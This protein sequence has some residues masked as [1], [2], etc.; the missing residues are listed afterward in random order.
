[1]HRNPGGLEAGSSPTSLQLEQVSRVTRECHGSR[2]CVP[3]VGEAKAKG[4]YS[5]SRTP[6]PEMPELKVEHADVGIWSGFGVLVKALIARDH[7]HETTRPTR[8]DYEH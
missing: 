2:K 3:D 4:T 1:M 6:F 5:Y 7:L 8:Y